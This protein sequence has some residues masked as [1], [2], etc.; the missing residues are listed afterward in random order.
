MSKREPYELASHDSDVGPQ[1][2]RSLE[3]RAKRGDPELKQEL[4]RELAAEFPPGHTTTPA[5]EE[6]AMVGRRGF[7]T[8]S[9][10]ALALAGAEGCR[11][12]L[13]KIVPYQKMPEQVI[14]GVP[15]HY[16]TVF[17][18]R[19][20]A[21]GLLVES[22]E[23]RPTKIEGNP[24]HPASMGAADLL[25]QASILDLYDM[26]RSIGAR[27][28]GFA[29][30]VGE[31]TGA[32]KAALAKAG[33]GD[34]LR[35]LMQPTNSP[36]V[37]RMRKAIAER[38]PKSKVH[39]YAPVNESSMREGT[40]VAFGKPMQPLYAYDQANVIVSLDSDFLQTEAGS[41]R[42]TKLFA[43]RRRLRS[44]QDTMSRLYVIEPMLSVTGSN[45]DHRFRVAASD[46]AGIAIALAAQLAQAHNV[47]VGDIVASA[48]KSAPPEAATWINAIAKDLASAGGRAIVVAGS[49]QPPVVHALAAAIND[50]LGA[51]GRTVV[52][53]DVT[54]VDE[55][56]NAADIAELAQAIAAKQVDTLVIVGGNPAYDAPADLKLEGALAMV[57]ASFHLSSH[58]DETSDKCTWHIPRAHE[59]EAWGDQRS[60]DGTISIQQ[61]LVAPLHGGVSDLELLAVVAN[62]PQTKAYDV[63]RESARSGWLVGKQYTDCAQTKPGEDECKDAA[64]GKIPV[65]ARDWDKDWNKALRD[66]VLVKGNVG[67]APRPAVNA[68]AITAAVMKRA[69]TAPLGPEN[70]EVTFAPCNKLFDGRH[71]N[72]VWL[73]ELPE[74]MTK[75]VWDN[76]A[77]LHPRTAEK[78]GVASGDMVKLTQ[79]ERSITLP[80]WVFPG[81]AASSIGVTLGWGRRKGGRLAEGRGFD[82]YPLRSSTT[83][84]FATGVKL[85]K[86]GETYKIGQTQENNSMEGRAISR[87]ATFEEYKAQP[88]F[89][90]LQS[91]PPRSLPLWKD[92]DYSKGHQWGMSIDLNACTGCNA[93]IIACQSENNVP[94]VGKIE[95]AR[96]REMQWIRLDRYFVEDDRHGATVDDPAIAHLPLACVHCEEAPCENVCPVNATSHSPEGLNE[97]AY[98]RCIGTRYC[99]NNC[100]YKVRRFNYLNWHNDAVWKKEG[101]LPETLQMQQN[102]NVSVRFRGVMEKCTY[103]VQRIQSVKINAK[104]ENREIRDGEIVTA[105]AQT[106]PADAIVFGDVN[107]PKT[108]VSELTMRDRRYALLAELGTKPRTTYLGKV[109]NPNPELTAKSGSAPAGG[110]A[111][112]DHKEHG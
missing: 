32:L 21:L 31:A 46:V 5:S 87:D 19:G 15:S 91:P 39:S 14:P 38:F 94:S 77:L 74:P 64:G 48:G 42:A 96:G 44:P 72:N 93:C 43:A 111:A 62:S 18:R 80:A 13:E 71:A 30:S 26:D 102:P 76:V 109:R 89:A 86:T 57:G 95:V 45:A 34:K 99:A 107:D 23:G 50:A 20:E 41:V 60:F 12:P 83:M 66:G 69:T 25:T 28:Q 56:E 2:W 53:A 36:S 27:S 10:A 68:A 49:R 84:G 79:G 65:F 7:L 59:Y 82:V 78:L 106:C 97:M 90:D 29:K 73:L 92:Q 101:G 88:T 24:S 35:V 105:C 1:F 40:R 104:R 63:V 100:P 22:H 54:D 4:A 51:V 67:T 8:L 55:K 103:C 11:R 47:R 81:Q 16:A 37:L 70:L 110:A 6:S 85:S 58:V 17:N 75:I 108:K 3:E 33:Q 112:P 61:P 98:N 52:Y 9:A